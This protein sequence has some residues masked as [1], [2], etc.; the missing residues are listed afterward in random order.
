MFWLQFRSR[1][2]VHNP[3]GLELSFNTIRSALNEGCFV[4]LVFLMDDLGAM[5]GCLRNL[6]FGF[7][8][9]PESS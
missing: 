5:Y 9:S 1:F 2:T 4:N 3:N 6:E 8:S 7:P